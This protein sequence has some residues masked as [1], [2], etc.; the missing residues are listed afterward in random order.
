MAELLT[1]ARTASVSTPLGTDL[2]L[3]L[4]GRSGGVES[5][6][7]TAR[8][9]LGNLPA[10]EAYIAPVEG[11]AEGVIVVPAKGYPKLEEQMTI[12]VKRGVVCAIEGGGKVGEEFR[13]LLELPTPGRQGARRNLAELG[14]GSNPR[15][16]LVDNTLEGEKIKGTVHIAIGDNAFLGGGVTADIHE[17]FVLSQ[18]DLSLDGRVVIRAG[19]WLV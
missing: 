5:G 10:G 6:L 7:L 15:A 19:E 14:I 2:T 8:G 11:K 13:A 12:R 1:E 3:D 18:P 9:S 17:D 4:Q 16:Q